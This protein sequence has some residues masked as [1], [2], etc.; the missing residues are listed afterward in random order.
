MNNHSYLS[1]SS[2]NIK[3]NKNSDINIRVTNAEKERYTKQARK[4]D[5]S[6]SQYLRELINLSTE[7]PKLITRMKI[8]TNLVQLTGTLSSL[9]NLLLKSQDT[10][11]T[12]EVKV[13]L[14]KAI[15]EVKELWRL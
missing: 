4:N 8:T 11:N 12:S 5:M 9:D 14:D 10:V 2:K 15:A 3:K 1:N 7:L 13:Y 6:T